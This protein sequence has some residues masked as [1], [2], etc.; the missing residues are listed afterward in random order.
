MK[1]GQDP[2]EFLHILETARDCLHGMGH[3]ISSERLDDLTLKPP[4][5]GHNFVRI[6]SFRDRE[7]VR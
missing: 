5:P 4:L 1:L 7:F 2:N 6:T 3:H